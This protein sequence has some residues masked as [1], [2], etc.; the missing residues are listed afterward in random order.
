MTFFIKISSLT[1]AFYMCLIQLY[2]RTPDG[3]TSNDIQQ[4]I[5]LSVP[6]FRHP[7]I[8]NS[9]S[10]LTY[11]AS[12]NK[13]NLTNSLIDYIK[14]AQISTE[15]PEVVYV[16]ASGS[17]PTEGQMRKD[18]DLAYAYALKW[19]QTGAAKDAEQTIAILN[20]WSGNFK[21]YDVV[22]GTKIVQAQLE[23]AWVA[24]TFTA[25]AEIIRHY[26]FKGVAGAGWSNDDIIQFS[27]FLSNLRDNYIN[28]L[29]KDVDAGKRQNNWGTSAGYAKMAM[30][31]FLDNQ[32]DYEDGMRIIRKLLPV[33]IKT[34]GEVYELC[35]RD[36]HHPQYSMTGLTY[37]AE[38]ARIQG[39]ESIFLA[40]SKRIKVGWEWIQ[41][42]FSG[43]VGCRDC[44]TQSVF[45][46]VEVAAA[47]YNESFA[48]KALARLQRPYTVTSDHTFAGFTT[49][50][51]WR[52]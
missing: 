13:P 27:K 28:L 30:G 32:A 6:E 18:A 36:C 24:P 44:S 14:A 17:T 50:T 8:I 48:I 3:T 10:S 42:A 21:C 7:G 52:K 45:P 22:E 20:G 34:S 46:G 43:K 29:V 41:S 33:V 51:H 2:Y 16:K 9:Q 39:D 4:K 31:V 26:K 38:I 35:S 49:Y 37:A 12:E 47:Y 19:V 11:V 15:Y 5:Q 25:A 40:D 23:A 1:A